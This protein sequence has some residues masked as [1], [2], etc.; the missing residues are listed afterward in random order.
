M[1][2]DTTDYAVAL[3]DTSALIDTLPAPLITHAARMLRRILADSGDDPLT[4]LIEM[5]GAVVTMIEAP[6][7]FGRDR[8]ID[9]GLVVSIIGSLACHD[10]AALALGQPARYIVDPR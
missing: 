4:A 3:A 10:Q 7:R 1:T 8:A 9:V 2:T 6:D 5:C